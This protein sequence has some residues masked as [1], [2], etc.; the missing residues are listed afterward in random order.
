LDPASTTGGD[1]AV[2][3]HQLVVM[4]VLKRGLPKRG[5]GV[6]SITRD[7]SHLESLK[8]E[9]HPAVVRVMIVSC[10][11]TR[12]GAE[13]EHAIVRMTNCALK[14]EIWSVGRTES[15]AA[16]IAMKGSHGSEVRTTRYI[17]VPAAIGNHATLLAPLMST[18]TEMWS[19][20]GAR[21]LKI[22]CIQQPPEEIAMSRDYGSGQLQ[23]TARPTVPVIVV[24]LETVAV[25]VL[26]ARGDTSTSG[27]HLV[28]GVGRSLEALVA[29][30]IS[31]L[32]KRCTHAVKV[33]K[34]DS[35]TCL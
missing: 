29:T 12:S 5:G 31:K 6:V 16:A 9:G 2:L 11:I 30:V 13:T 1:V 19:R 3:R 17:E 32:K 8:E 18:E 7:V 22:A 34:G 23:K 27:S 33:T 25:R 14:R 21:A 28:E 26:A 20:A 4:P 24:S 35:E 15:V 10:E